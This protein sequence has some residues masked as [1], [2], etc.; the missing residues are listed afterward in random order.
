MPEKH[1]EQFSPIETDRG[2]I[3]KN[4]SWFCAFALAAVILLGCSRSPANAAAE[5]ASS[6]VK[7]STYGK[8][9]YADLVVSANGNIHAVFTDQPAYDKP[10]YIYYRM[11][12]NGGKTWSEP[13]NLSDDESGNAA[14]C[15]RLVEDGKGRIYCVWKYVNANEL[16]DGPG[17]NAS[18]VIMFRCLEGGNWSNRKLVSDPKVPTYSWFVAVD[19]KGTAHIIWSQMAK[20]A[21]EMHFAASSY[22][23]LVRQTSFEGA[24]LG[25]VKDLIVP[26]PIMTKE[27][28]EASK[29]AGKY[30]KY[31]DT[32]P[33]QDGMI[34][35]AGYVDAAGTAHFVLEGPGID[36]GPAEQKT[37]KRIMH[38]SGT[39]LTPVYAYA[40]FQTYNNF[41]NPPM[42]AVDAAGKEYLIR[43][44]EKSEKPCIRVY[45]VTDGE[46]GDGVDILKPK[47]GPG[48][49]SNWQVNALPGGRIS[50]TAALS[51]KG[52]YNPEDLDLYLTIF[53]GKGNWSEPKRLTDNAA[54]ETFSSKDTGALSSV[55]VST[56]YKP[57]FAST[58]SGKNGVPA[59]VIVN[60][61]SSLI[62]VNS[63]AS[64]GSGR[65][66]IVSSGGR[67]NNPH[68][69]FLQL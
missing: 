69:F 6:M 58:V 46:L 23:D 60:V 53:D 19:P 44:P 1:A 35:L 64:T 31:E 13:K 14:S 7:I 59:L 47:T 32:Q 10:S 67:V 66:V 57:R 48:M 52:G 17:G 41:N 22:A 63:A 62:G 38:W 49:L 45:P 54:K 29:K 28:Q 2:N 27:E 16:L 4:S 36:E 24:A 25:T 34:N 21:A 5:A 65:A 15:V 51:E 42:L 33:H 18:G 3:M 8:S 40:R 30:P 37:G 68:T 56:S 26:K 61:E 12:S 55:A 50:V 39:K 20:D 9:G 43:A 11:S